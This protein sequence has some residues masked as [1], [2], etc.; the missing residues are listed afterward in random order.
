[1]K[2]IFPEDGKKLT[3][4]FGGGGELIHTTM[5]AHNDASVTPQ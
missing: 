2:T 1:M 4:L 5:I 3:F